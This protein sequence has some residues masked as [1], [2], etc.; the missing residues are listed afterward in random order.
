MICPR[1]CIEC[2]NAT[3]CS[4]YQENVVIVED[5]LRTCKPGTRTLLDL[6]D[7]YYAEERFYIINQTF[8]FCPSGCSFCYSDYD[9]LNPQIT[10]NVICLTCQ[11]GY[12]LV[13]QTCVSCP[14][15]C[16]SCSNTSSCLLC[17]IGYY[18]TTSKVCVQYTCSDEC[19]ACNTINSSICIQCK[20][21]YT[22]AASGTCLKCLGSCS[23]SCD[24]K[25]ISVCLSCMK[26][27]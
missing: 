24:P 1:G 27:F 26:G 20:P 9:Y 6:P 10:P 13:N 5:T 2:V 18:L 25:N 7:C 14:S 11:K 16:L 4:K 3:K 15:N 23:G 22:L 19:S 21:G 12:M 17:K 8:Y